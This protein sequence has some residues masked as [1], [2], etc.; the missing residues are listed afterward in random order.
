MLSIASIFEN[1]NSSLNWNGILIFSNLIFRTGKNIQWHWIFQ[2]TSGDQ[3]GDR[4]PR[5]SQK[6]RMIKFSHLNIKGILLSLY[7]FN[8]KEPQNPRSS[9]SFLSQFWQ[10]LETDLLVFTTG[11]GHTNMIFFFVQGSKVSWRNLILRH[12]IVDHYFQ[13]SGFFFEC[14]P[15]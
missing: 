5:W 14:W 1:W 2:K 10:S 15:Q 6:I 3:Q 13:V 12:D 7:F 9:S 8:H 4:T 11:T